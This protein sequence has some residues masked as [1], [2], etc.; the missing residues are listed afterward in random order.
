MFL[1]NY[2]LIV[3]NDICLK[4]RSNFHICLKEFHPFQL[5]LPFSPMC[6]M[7]C[8][9]DVFRVWHVQQTLYYEVVLF[10]SNLIFSCILLKTSVLVMILK[11]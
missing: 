9:C 1:H 4:H 11:L 5:I 10:K 7:E 3:F 6:N 8:M 2:E